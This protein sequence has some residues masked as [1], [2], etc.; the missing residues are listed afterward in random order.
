MDVF[1][2]SPLTMASVHS[3]SR[4]STSS[5]HILLLKWKPLDELRWISSFDARFRLN[6]VEFKQYYG[7]NAPQF[8]RLRVLHPA[9]AM[10]QLQ[11]KAWYP[12]QQEQRAQ[13]LGNSVAPP[14]VQYIC[15]LNHLGIES[16]E[17]AA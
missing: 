11:T 14:I 5:D 9:M 6:K 17:C 15:F 16:V 4:G 10:A 3:A 2:Q 12:T 7:L 8:D 13:R 1:H